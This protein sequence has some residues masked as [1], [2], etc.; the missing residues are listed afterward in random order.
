LE[1]AGQPINNS[2]DLPH[3]V[4]LIAPETTVPVLIRRDGK[5]RRLNV[6]VGG[7]DADQRP[8]VAATDGE[9][10]GA[11]LGLVL[12]TAEDA[13][14][15]EMGLPGGV[16][17]LEVRPDSPAADGGIAGGDVIT[18]LGSNAIQSLED[19]ES[20]VGQLQPGQSVAVRLIRRGAPM[21]LAIR[22]PQPEQ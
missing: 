11:L 2:A 18:R 13:M 22:V 10:Q 21:F 16:V 20:A 17:V 6:T 4:G 7:L 8:T 1:F 3:V 15:A 12:E 9:R 14:M 19:F 5:D